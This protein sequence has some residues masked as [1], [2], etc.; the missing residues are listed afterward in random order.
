MI[1]RDRQSRW[2]YPTKRWAQSR[3]SQIA[4]SLLVTQGLVGVAVGAQINHSGVL[5]GTGLKAR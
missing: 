5:L 3:S 1:I 2:T 4:D